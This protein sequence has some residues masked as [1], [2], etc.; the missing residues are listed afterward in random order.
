[1]MGHG[2]GNDIAGIYNAKHR[3]RVIVNAGDIIARA[4]E[5][6]GFVHYSIRTAIAKANLAF[7]FQAF[8]RCIVGKVI[9][10][11]MGHGHG[12]DIAGFIVAAEYGVIAFDLQRHI[13]ADEF[14]RSIAHQH[15]GQ[16]PCLGEHLKAV[17]DTKH[18][19]AAFGLIHHIAH[20]GR[21]GRH[22]A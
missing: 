14:Q 18:R 12:N 3:S 17:A 15:T 16:K 8:E 1:M 22:G 11:M 21:M 13:P 6:Y 4:I 10:I 7:S 9:A 2:H 5:I 20:N 19:R